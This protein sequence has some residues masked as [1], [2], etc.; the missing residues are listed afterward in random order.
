MQLSMTQNVSTLY[1]AVSDKSQHH[2]TH[3]K[4]KQFL[5]TSQLNLHTLS[6]TFVFLRKHYLNNNV[7][8]AKT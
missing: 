3:L 5:P 7:S 1:Q 6:Y 4:E 2:S 8:Q